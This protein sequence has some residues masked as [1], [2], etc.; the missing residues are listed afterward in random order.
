MRINERFWSKA[1]E[2][3]TAE[4]V[5]VCVFGVAGTT[6]RV[7]QRRNRTRTHRLGLYWAGRG[8]SACDCSI[9]ALGGP[10]SA[11]GPERRRAASARSIATKCKLSCS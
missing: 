7:A 10:P 9:W 5:C 2:G 1:K 11:G 4:L 8:R 6:G 3:G